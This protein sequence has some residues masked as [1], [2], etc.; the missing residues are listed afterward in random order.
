MELN[1]DFSKWVL[2]HADEIEW[3]ASPMPGV[4]RRMLDRIGGEVARATSVV[5]YHPGSIFSPHVHDEG[6]EFLVL[7]GVF[8][9]EHGDF[10][11]GYYIRN[12]P[13]SSHAPASEPG[14]LILVKLRQFD[15][16]DRSHVRID[17]NKMARIRDPERGGVEVTPLF[18]D[19]REDVR[20]EK[21][22]PRA[23]VS[24]QADGGAEVFVLEGSFAADCGLLR[25][26]SWLRI[27]PG[28]SLTATTGADGAKL[29][30]KTGHL[31]F[32]PHISP[33]RPT[34]ST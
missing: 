19:H 1:S 9:D 22:A 7:E 16:A 3:T 4:S 25:P 5:R 12:P 21:W 15:P 13:G 34:A 20:L 11:T 31:R 29:W 8:Q 2:L 14:C 6:E 33:I 24:L 23:S 18:C 30:I 32:S 26:H 17:T 27:P 10:P 28:G